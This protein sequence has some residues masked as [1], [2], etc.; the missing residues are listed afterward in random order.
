M[1]D[2]PGPTRSPQILLWG[3]SLTEGSPGVAFTSFL[4]KSFSGIDWVNRGRGGDTALSLLR[5]LNQES[6]PEESPKSELA[7]LWVGVNDVFAD[8]LPGY[9]L[10]KLARRQ[11]P[12][13]NAD[14]FSIIY[15][16]ILERLRLLT[17]RIITLPPL[18]VGEN[19]S[20]ELNRRLHDLGDKISTISDDS[21]GCRFVDLRESLPLNTDSPPS[22]LPVNP[23]SKIIEKFGQVEIEDFDRAAERRGLRWTYDGVHLN[24]LGA[25]KVAS[26]LTGV[27]SEELEAPYNERAK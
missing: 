11:R 6:I 26:V 5:R 18:F 8:L 21:P 15:K 23:W 20:T 12:T 25:G 4:N 27:I 22:F 16:S 14:D 10:I 17:P 7:V 1:I 13:R 19:P 3:D 9:S 2:D 24:S